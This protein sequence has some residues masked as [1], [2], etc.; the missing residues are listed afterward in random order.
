MT[1]R[2]MLELCLKAFGAFQTAHT[3]KLFMKEFTLPPF[4]L[5]EGTAPHKL[6]QRMQE[7]L[8][9]HLRVKED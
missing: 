3:S 5:F 4:G 2:E 1:D 9:A 8:R 6:A 7:A